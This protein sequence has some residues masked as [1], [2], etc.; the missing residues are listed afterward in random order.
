[1]PNILLK[2]T[3]KYPSLPTLGNSLESHTAVLQALRDAVQTHERRDG[4]PLSSF[5][6]LREL[7]DLGLVRR[8]GNELVLTFDPADV[9][10]GG[11]GGSSTLAGLSDV[12]VGAVA[13]GDALVYD[14]TYGLWLPEVISAGV[15][16]N[17]SGS[18]NLIDEV[19]LSVA[20]PTIS[21]N[22]IPQS[23]SSLMLVFT[24]NTGT[25]FDTLY[26]QFNGDTAANYDSTQDFGGA[27]GTGGASTLNSAKPEIGSMPAS[28]LNAAQ[29]LTGTIMIP[30]YSDN[31]G[32]KGSQIH[33]GRRD[34]AAFFDECYLHNWH[35]TAAITDILLGVAAGNNFVAGTRVSL[36]GLSGTAPVD[37]ATANTTP[38]SHP[39]LPDA[40][41][42]EFEGVVL[43]P[44]W[45]W[46]NQGGA[47]DTFANGSMVLTAPNSAGIAWRIIEQPVPAGAWRFRVKVSAKLP[48]TNFCR[49]GLLVYRTTSS[50]LLSIDSAYSSGQKIEAN[51]WNVNG[52]YIGSIGSSLAFPG[53]QNYPVYLEI[54]YDG[55]SV[56]S[57]RWSIQGVDGT[58]TTIGTEAQA[59]NLGGAADK[60]AIG[61]NTESSAGA[62]LG[63][64]DWFRRVA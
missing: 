55:S 9:G 35:N 51:S 31:T 13:D 14:A 10:G 22:S 44:K 27:G 28:A 38:D 21:F 17:V 19:V 60:I 48:Q 59:T 8:V 30:F 3:R 15:G 26:M 7:I 32:Y 47:T 43:D 11:S 50:K 34:A 54:E 45:A 20:A 23:Y 62:A 53:N 37:A 42:D 52:P 40:T 5:V 46:R 61:V 36:Y 49:A 6:R 2:A 57:F 24:M 64:F 18:V 41:D 29:R 58:F 4:D 56:Y 16:S 12:D 25:Q 39:S 63:I 1:M 33:T